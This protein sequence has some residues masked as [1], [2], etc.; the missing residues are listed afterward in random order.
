VRCNARCLS[1]QVLSAGK[2]FR[3]K[4]NLGCNLLGIAGWLEFSRAHRSRQAAKS[5]PAGRTY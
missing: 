3:R 5:C 2:D 1:M 4:A